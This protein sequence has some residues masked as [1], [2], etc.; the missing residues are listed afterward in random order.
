MSQTVVNRLEIP[1]LVAGSAPRGPQLGERPD[2]VEHVKVQ[3]TVTL[4]E[5]EISMGK[6]FSLSAG[7]VLTL[8]RAADAPVDVRLNGK[9]IARGT[10]VAVDD[11]FG[12]R[13]TEILAAGA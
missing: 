3:L 2:L 6:L 9:V 8:D 7:E 4:G 13:I 1:A 11:R 10:L 5:A 12:V